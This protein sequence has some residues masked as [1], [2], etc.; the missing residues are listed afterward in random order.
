MLSILAR[1]L[2]TFINMAVG[3]FTFKL[4][5][6]RLNLLKDIPNLELAN[7]IYPYTVMCHMAVMGLYMILLLAA[8]KHP[9]LTR[10]AIYFELVLM[11]IQAFYPVLVEA[12]IIGSHVLT[13]IVINFGTSAFSW[14]PAYITSLLSLVPVHVMRVVYYGDLVSD[15]VR[16]CIILQIELTVFLILT[17]LILSYFG[18]IYVEAKGMLTGNS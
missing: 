15:M 1:I 16:Q 7:K 4:S 3:E 17:H 18:M 9:W 11:I 12:F 13:I 8:L 14:W 2:T 10:L 6:E 5:D